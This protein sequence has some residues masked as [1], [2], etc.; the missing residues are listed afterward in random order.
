MVGKHIK[1]L[2][3]NVDDLHTGGVYSLVKNVIEH[4]SKEI[5]IDIGAIEKF[6]NQK[7]VEHFEALG[8]KI[9]YLGYEGSKWKK[10]FVCYKNLKKLL[11]ENKYDFVHIHADVANK[12]LVSA[13][14]AKRVGVKRVVVHSHAAGVDGNHRTFK[15]VVHRLCRIFLKNVATDFVACSDVAAVWMYPGIPKEKVMIIQNGIDLEKFRFKDNIRQNVREQ[16][17]ITDEVLIGHVGRFAYQK[18]HEYIL[19]IAKALKEKQMHSKILLVGEGPEKDRIKAVAEEMNLN[20]ILVF[21]GTSNEVEKLFMAMDVFV[22]PSHFEGLPIVG[23]EAQA[24]GLP[25]IFSDKITSQAKLLDDVTF[26]G[27]E[28]AD[29]SSWVDDVNHYG[30]MRRDR[31]EAYKRLREEKYSIED[32]VQSFMSLYLGV[33][34]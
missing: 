28:D 15:V 12:L 5:Q 27:I 29:I 1:V 10:Q 13:L 8:S 20:D 4:S 2:E 9:Y 16:L 22:L 11:E 30:S 14:A 33:K 17:G 19:K 18:N 32:T 26:L 7:N 25:V 6:V 3:V 21:Y 24:S 23:V 34:K 31:T